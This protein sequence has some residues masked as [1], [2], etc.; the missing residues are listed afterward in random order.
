MKSRNLFGYIWPA[1]LVIASSVLYHV[2]SK[3]TPGDVVPF[4][5]LIITYAVA[6]A[7]SFVL[8]FATSKQKNFIQELKKT[9]WASWVYGLALV[10]TEAGFVYVYRAGWAISV[11]SLIVNISLAC[12][13]I[14]IGAA[15]YKEKISLRQLA[16][17]AVC[18]LGMVLINL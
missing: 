1:V 7:C 12:V 6:A 10:C 15:F 16:G 4:A 5:T 9:N 2:F 11:G 8:F 18:I 3:E 17:L 14:I 13:L